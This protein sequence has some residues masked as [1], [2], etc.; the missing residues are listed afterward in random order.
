M[1][2]SALPITNRLVIPPLI[3]I[4]RSTRET[5]V[6][7]KEAA[8]SPNPAAP[9]QIEVIE[10]DHVRMIA[11][12]SRQPT[13]SPKRIELG[14]KRAAT[15]MEMSRPTVKAPQNIEVM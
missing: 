12:L 11:V 2:P 5:V 9:I 15:G 7:N 1:A 13:R 4:L 10:V 6:G 3:C 8:E 14:R